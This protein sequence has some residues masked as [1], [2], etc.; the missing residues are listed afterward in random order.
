MSIM[1]NRFRAVGAKL[2]EFTRDI[3][4][5]G[6]PIILALLGFGI[7]GWTQNTF[8]LYLI[9]LAN[10]A[11]CSLIKLYFFTA[12]PQPMKYETW[13]EKIEAGSMPS[14]HSSRWAVIAAFAVTQDINSSLVLFLLVSTV[15]VGISRVLLRKHH[16]YDVLAGWFIGFLF[17]WLVGVL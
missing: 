13:W 15:L 3:T 10:E 9:W 1:S 6:S 12:R 14:I 11:F 8:T 2:D 17:G 7:F 4:G 16:W 5:L